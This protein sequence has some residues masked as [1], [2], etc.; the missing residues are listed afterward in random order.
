MPPSPARTAAPSHK[1]RWIVIV[2]QSDA[3]ER[4]MAKAG[5]SKRPEPPKSAS[6]KSADPKERVLLAA[7]DVAVRIGWRRAALADIAD[8]AGVTLAELHE[9]FTDKAAMLR[10]IVDLADKKVL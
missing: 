2:K 4:P 5:K 6:P 1:K 10:G 3:K 8:A 7:M 9:Q